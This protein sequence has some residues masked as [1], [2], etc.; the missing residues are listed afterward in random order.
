MACRPAGAE[1]LSETMLGYCQLNYWEQ[2]SVEILNRNL[3]IF[4]QENSFKS[5]VY[6]MAA[7]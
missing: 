2:T 1:P 3:H 6:K 5:V 4:I 7:I